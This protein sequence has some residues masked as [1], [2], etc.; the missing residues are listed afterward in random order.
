MIDQTAID[1]LETYRREGRLIRDAWTGTDA[2]GRETAC[3]LAALVPECGARQ[4]AFACPADVMPPW[5]AH[6]TPWIDDAGTVDAWPGHIT[7]FV[8]IL[9]AWNLTEA[10]SQR[11]DYLCRALIVREARSHTTDTRAIAACDAVIALCDRAAAGSS[12]PAEERDAAMSAAMSAAAYAAAS[13]AARAAAWDAASAAARAAA[14]ASAGTAA[15][16]AAM[17]AAG[18]AASA[19]ASAAEAEAA[20]AAASDRM[21]DGILTVLETEIAHGPRG[22]K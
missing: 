14:R 9:R 19:A 18:A 8:A 11:C 13:A 22:S 6:L 2:Q 16:S 21:I 4:D 3:L 10:Q 17:S 5:L 15:M 20:R 7:R 1:R 12:P